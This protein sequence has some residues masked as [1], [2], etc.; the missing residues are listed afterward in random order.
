M[1]SSS[2]PLIFLDLDDVICLNE[3]YGGYDVLVQPRPLDLWEKLF[4]REAADTLLAATN[5]SNPRIVLTT[6]WIRLFERDTFDEIFQ[7]TGLGTIAECLHEKHEA[8]QNTGE[9][10]LHAIDRWMSNHYRGEGFVVID[11]HLSGTELLNSHFD[12]AG[13]LILCDVGVGLQASHLV[14]IRRA[15]HLG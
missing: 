10:R 1:S 15:L 6:S 3:P 2:Q 14:E 9:S 12:H 5:E 7:S 8:R 11:D 4:S 13:R